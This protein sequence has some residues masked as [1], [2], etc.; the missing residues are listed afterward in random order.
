MYWWLTYKRAGLLLSPVVYFM[1]YMAVIAWT[2]ALTKT[3][4]SV[5]ALA[6]EF[7]VTLVPIA[8]VYNVS[9]Y[10]TMLLLE[11]A[12]LPVVFSDPFGFGWNLFDL[13]RQK[14]YYV[15]MGIVWHTQVALI[16]IGHVISVYLA[17][18]VAL[19][20]FPSKRLALVS[21]IPMLLLMVAYTAIGLYVLSLPLALRYL[22]EG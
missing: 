11:G 15:D 14:P 21:Q 10:Y 20:V 22:R 5:R 16:L 4:L 8:L 9:H 18:R 1:L 19:R 13:E 2:R 3:T 7:I 6:L 12:R 17:H